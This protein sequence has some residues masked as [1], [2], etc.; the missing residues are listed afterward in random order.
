MKF[1]GALFVL[2]IVAAVFMLLQN[3][4]VETITKENTFLQNRTQITM[5]A[6][7]FVSEEKDTTNTSNG[8]VLEIYKTTNIN[9]SEKTFGVSVPMGTYSLEFKKIVPAGKTWSYAKMDG[10]TII[11]SGVSVFDKENTSLYSNSEQVFIKFLESNTKS[12]D[13]Y[14]KHNRAPSFIKA[15]VDILWSFDAKKGLL[16][17]E[18]E[19][20]INDVSIY[21]IDFRPIGAVFIEDTKRAEIV[22]NE[23]ASI[24]DMFMNLN[25]TTT[26][27]KEENKNLKDS[28]QSLIEQINAARKDRESASGKFE[29]VNNT[30]RFIENEVTSNVILSPSTAVISIMVAIVVL[31][32]CIDIIFFRERVKKND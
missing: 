6:V 18:S 13:I 29:K 5:P 12:V 26:K 8:V 14:S 19:E 24:R 27:M 32:L 16:H 22:S 20:N 21:F 11:P 3:N 7:P 31:I 23:L 15:D 9:N 2:F 25:K 28:S 10:V 30:T 1:Y 4:V 17:I